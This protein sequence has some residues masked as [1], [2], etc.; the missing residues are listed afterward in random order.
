[1]QFEAHTANPTEAAL[2]KAMQKNYDE[3]FSDFYETPNL[4]M[5]SALFHP[6]ELS[7]VQHMLSKEVFDECLDILVADGVS[8]ATAAHD[9]V[10]NATSA[11]EKEASESALDIPD[12]S[13]VKK[14]E[15]FKAELKYVFELFKI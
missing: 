11:D 2:K 4:A 12:L 7:F 14:A 8:L 15:D 9:K 6:T 10:P 1:M 5:L 3:K 13:T